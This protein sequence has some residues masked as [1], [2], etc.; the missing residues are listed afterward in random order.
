MIC[1]R[2]SEESRLL[3]IQNSN[4]SFSIIVYGLCKGAQTQK[5]PL[6]T[7]LRS[8]L[9]CLP[10]VSP[11]SGVLSTETL[12]CFSPLQ[13]SH[14]R[15]CHP[16]SQYHSRSRHWVHLHGTEEKADGREDNMRRGRRRKK[17]T[18][19]KIRRWHVQGAQSNRA[20]VG[21]KCGRCSL[22]F[23]GLLLFLTFHLM[24]ETM[25]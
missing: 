24:E 5:G 18:R 21:L 22:F 13:I 15:V 4:I 11:S 6:K 3:N 2:R 25:S 9:Q 1:K 17:S 12:N 19:L 14:Q 7:K 8:P 23:F 16:H 20:H 10:S